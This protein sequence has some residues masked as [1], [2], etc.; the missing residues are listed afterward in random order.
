MKKD[1]V[2]TLSTPD[3]ID[4]PLTELLRKGARNLIQ[5]AIEAELEELL[6]QYAGQTDEQG[7]QAVVRNGYLPERE[8][9]TGLGPEKVKV[10]KMRSR[11][12]ESV[13]FQSSLVPPYSQGPPNRGRVALA[14]SQGHLHGSDAT[15]TRC[16]GRS[17]GQGI[18]SIGSQPTQT[19]MG[20]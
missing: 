7:R 15:G 17:S 18:V 14:L 11:T 4:D 20:S 13:V 5:Q 19:A 12:G 9:L 16:F 6:A 3:V 10:P 1:N 8:I 2:F